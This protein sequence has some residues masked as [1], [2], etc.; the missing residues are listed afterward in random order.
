MV[1]PDFDP[2]ALY[3]GPLVIRWYGLMYLIGF[4]TAW[5]LGRYRARR[6]DAVISPQQMDDLLFYAALGIILG[7]RIGYVLFYNTDR[8]LSDPLQIFRV[9]EGGMSFHG[10]MLGV[11][12]AMW[13]YGRKTG[14]SF[15]QVTDFMAPFVPIGLGAGR[16]GNFING[17]LWGAPTDLP[18]GM[19]FPF[20]DD[21]PRHPSMLYEALL[22]GRHH[23]SQFT[24]E[25]T[26]RALAC[27]Q[28]ALSLDPEYADAL[29]FFAFY[30]L[31]MAYM[32]EDPRAVIREPL[33]WAASTTR[34]PRLKPLMSRLRRGKWP[35]FG[36]VPGGNSVTSAPCSWICSARRRWRAG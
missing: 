11:F 14:R 30:H 4:A 3:V 13:L 17:E 9:W 1:F 24:P 18:W 29:A 22:E 2:V 19:V 34:V 5:W 12:V 36:G 15:F 7:G 26:E 32:F 27:F 23:F 28:R 31:T 35:R 6:A 25:S 10:C 21:Q 8:W 20:V 16:I 33:R